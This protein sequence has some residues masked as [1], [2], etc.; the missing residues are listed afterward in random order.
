MRQTGSCRFPLRHVFCCLNEQFKSTSFCESFN[1]YNMLHVQTCTSAI[2]KQ[3]FNLILQ[4]LCLLMS[5][6]PEILRLHL[7][8]EINTVHCK[9]STAELILCFADQDSD[10]FMS[11]DDKTPIVRKET[12]KTS[13]RH[14]VISSLKANHNL[15]LVV[16]KL[17]YR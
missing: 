6:K 10:E 16:R 7:R 1:H 14:D 13:H 3:N 15:L 17:N 5:L 8:N 4:Q 12:S 11:I 9:V 2:L